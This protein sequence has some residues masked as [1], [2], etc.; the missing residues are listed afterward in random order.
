MTSDEPAHGSGPSPPAPAVTSDSD[1][2]RQEAL[3]AERSK[4][5][6]VRQVPIG[7]P[8]DPASYAELKRRAAQ[9]DDE[10][11]DDDATLDGPAS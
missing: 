9:P 3:P 8:I 11:G 4:S 7:V 1:T 2:D 5:E 6:R 10:R